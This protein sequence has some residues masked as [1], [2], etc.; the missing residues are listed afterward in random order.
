MLFLYI[1]LTGLIIGVLMG[2]LLP[3]NISLINANIMAVLAL[4]ALDSILSSYHAKLN[5]EFVTKI[6]T[7]QFLLNSILA[8]GLITLGN[9]T[10]TNLFIPVSVV[11]IARIFYFLTKINKTIIEKNTSVS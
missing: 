4:C 3:L 9:I 10:G 8:I 2:L 5:E 6:F 11:I 7:N 1:S